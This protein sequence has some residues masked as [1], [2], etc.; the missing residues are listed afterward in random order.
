HAVCRLG[1]VYGPRQ[2]PHGEAG[3][4]SIFSHRLWQGETPTLYGHGRPTRDYVHVHDVV[5]AMLKASGVTGV[6]NVATGIETDVAS[7][8]EMLQRAAGT[9]LEPKLA[10]LREGELERSCMDATRAERELG[11]KPAIPLSEGLASTYTALVEEF[12]R[13]GSG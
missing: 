1:N 7:L 9:K 10:P 6:F 13:G 5:S 12:E 2:S 11:W 4:V 8:Y 3:V